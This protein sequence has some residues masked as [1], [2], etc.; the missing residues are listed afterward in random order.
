[1]LLTFDLSVLRWNYYTTLDTFLTYFVATTNTSRRRIGWVCQLLQICKQFLL[2]SSSRRKMVDWHAWF[3]FQTYGTRFHRDVSRAYAVF[4]FAIYYHL[5]I[6]YTYLLYQA[7]P[8]QAFTE[9]N[10]QQRPGICQACAC[11]PLR[12]QGQRSACRQQLAVFGTPRVKQGIPRA[13]ADQKSA[14][15]SHP[16]WKK[17]KGKA[18]LRRCLAYANLVTGRAST[19][20]SFP[21]VFPVPLLP[22]VHHVSRICFAN[23]IL[24][25]PTK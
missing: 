19:P 2:T 4:Q 3:I 6:I 22:Y 1:M 7:W 25:P 21:L 11:R 10:A 5:S 23:A 16:I 13:Y 9:K 24:R 12:I 20:P 18:L 15:C 8:I 17:A 14:F